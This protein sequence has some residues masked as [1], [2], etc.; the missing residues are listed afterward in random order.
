MTWE[1]W[2]NSSYNTI[3]AL[4]VDNIVYLEDP[5]EVWGATFITD[6]DFKAQSPSDVIISNGQYT[7]Y[8]GG[9]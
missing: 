9:W 1:A 5:G 4:I 3:S 6:Y 7:N 2:V 8:D